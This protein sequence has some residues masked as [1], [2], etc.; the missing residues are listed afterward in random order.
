MTR[1]TTLPDVTLT[2]VGE[3]RRPMKPRTAS[4][5]QGAFLVVI[6]LVSLIPLAAIFIG[7]FQDGN[8]IMRNGISFSIDFSALSLDNY[9]MLFT[10]SGLY[11]GWFW[12]S[13]VLTVVQV[14]G[15][16]LVSSFVAYPRAFTGEA[17]RIVV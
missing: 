2:E 14:I 3:P 15:T 4:L 10:D 12:N 8:E 7:T 13:L 9:T 6:A 11:F 1:T 5:I 17:V 16:L